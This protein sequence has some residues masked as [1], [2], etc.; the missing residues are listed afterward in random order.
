MRD[1]RLYQIAV[2]GSLLIY[3]LIALDFDIGIPQ[4]VA[5]IG[6]AL[7]AQGVASRG[8]RLPRVEWKSALI[9]SL[10][11]C[12]LLR[13]DA[14]MLGAVAGSIA[15]GSK[16]VLRS[17]G[18]HVFNPTNFALVAMLAATSRAWVSSGQ[19]G[20][21]TTLGFLMACLG[22]L[23]VTR[24]RRADVSFAFLSAWSGILIF[25]SLQLAE[26]MTI[27]LH[28]LENGSL[29]LF[30]FFMI[31]DPKTTP[32]ARAGRLLFAVLVAAF[33]WFVQ[34]RL[35]RP[36][37]LLWSLAASSPLV[38]LIDRLLPAKRYVWDAPSSSLSTRRWAMKRALVLTAALLAGSVLT[39][40]DAR[41]FCGFYVS[42]ADAK[43]FNKAS[44]VVMV[45]DGDRTVLTM[46][47][48]Y[49]GDPSEFALVIP[50]P[51]SITREQIHI[52]DPAI[53]EHIDAY[54]APRLVEYFDSDP[55]A[56]AR[57]ERDFKMARNAPALAGL[58]AA[59]SRAK[60]LGVRIEARYTVGEYDILILSAQ[61]SGGLA[62]WL[63]ENGY[64]VPQGAA[65]VLSSYIAQKMRFFVARV[66]L[67]ERA[68][69]GTV[70]LRP[71]QIAYE[72]PKFMLPL[73]L[74][75]ANADGAQEMFVYALTRS[76]RVEA[77]NYRTVKIPS[78]VD[79]PEFVKDD[80]A[81]FYR[82]LFKAQAKA[83]GGNAVFV[84]Y[85]WDMGWCDPCA[86]EPL[87]AGELRSL[88][89]FWLPDGGAV[90]DVFVTRLHVRYDRA[91]FPEDLVFQAT[92][93]RENFQGR[94]VLRHPWAGD[95]VCDEARSYRK[96]LL[97]RLNA[98]AS[99]LADLTGW[100]RESIV[101]RM[102]LTKIQAQVR[103]DGEPW[104]RGLW[105]Q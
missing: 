67:G 58:V 42:K 72:S 39:A 41:A 44:Q 19:W 99:T 78:D 91:H 2:L 45:R 11:L 33:A 92:G 3:G 79:I 61:Q 4:V 49:R 15:V 12:L 37:A 77:T 50:V 54:S 31:S 62:T 71:I 34:F 52:G 21:A 55:C 27:P 81:P 56:A 29:L 13:T 25:R 53:V 10:S 9:S 5:T 22:T 26:P 24:A 40:G 97:A 18:K 103:L 47:S 73:R 23:V 95:T 43:L 82:D 70:S 63:R 101:L 8:L 105:K 86:A 74:G 57:R 7:L 94:Y 38:P 64:K 35:F 87:V 90:S 80:F 89:V 51:T 32:D 16:F 96:D 28:R 6:A 76:G 98:Q 65:D 17:K 93:N 69:L 60:S 36:N 46:A 30:A 75:M 84:E 88:G 66:N 59:E 68:K 1:P 85:A 100:P 20:S 48:D 102:D 104:W 14:P 83:Q